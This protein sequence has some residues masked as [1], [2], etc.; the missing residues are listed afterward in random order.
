MQENK[1]IFQALARATEEPLDLQK[2]ATQLNVPLAQVQQ[3]EAELDKELAVEQIIEDA[4]GPEVVLS[5]DGQIMVVPEQTIAQQQRQARIA[6]ITG[7]PKGLSALHDEVQATAGTLV[8][9]I[10][11]ALDD[12]NIPTKDLSTLTVALT[13]IQQAFFNRPVTNVQINNGGGEGLLAS[14]RDKLQS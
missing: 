12:T 11:D 5:E 3:W 10:G 6:K 13:S 9:R 8:H 1:T 2:I 4:A 14:F 7:G